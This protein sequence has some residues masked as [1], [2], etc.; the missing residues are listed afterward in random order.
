MIKEVLQVY[1]MNEAS[2]LARFLDAQ[3]E[4]FD[5][6]LQ[7]IKEGKKRSHWMW[8]IF[9]QLKGLGFTDISKY[10]AIKDLREASEYLNHPIL[11]SRL[12]MISSALLELTTRD[13]Y[14]IF[15]L[16]DELKLKSS[17]TLFSLVD[18][19]DAVFQQVIDEFF[20]GEKDQKTLNL[21][22]G[23]IGK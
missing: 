3:K 5:E 20:G 15:G 7:E 13:A 2:G 23:E 4:T 16:P 11:G 6:A 18:G 22:S 14:K 17:M 21:L 12:I 9:P 8:Y 1:D 10:Y 19:A